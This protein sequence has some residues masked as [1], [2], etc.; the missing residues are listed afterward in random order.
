MR[1]IGL[2]GTAILSA[3]ALMFSP[4][5]DAQS[6]NFPN[7]SFK[8][9]SAGVPIDGSGSGCRY[10]KSDFRTHCKME[11]STIGGF[12][13]QYF[14]MNLYNGRLSEISVIV[15]G[16]DRIVDALIARYGAPCLNGPSRQTLK[17]GWYGPPIG[18]YR[19]NLENHYT[20]L[21]TWCFSTGKLAVTKD[22]NSA[23]YLEYIDSI[24]VPK[25]PQIDF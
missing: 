11:N 14:Y 1:S 24:N 16:D 7:F 23:Y 5:A 25:T 17:Y 13:T 19:F 9:I 4:I 20:E 22:I 15:R 2:V 3:S 21:H 6:S 8:D 12:T 18:P 10:W